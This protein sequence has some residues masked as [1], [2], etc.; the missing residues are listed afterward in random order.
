MKSLQNT[1]RI[2]LISHSL[3]LFSLKYFSL[4]TL[5]QPLEFKGDVYGVHDPT[6]I[7]AEGKYYLFSTGQG[8]QI[9]CSDDLVTWDL[10]SAVYF[11][12]PKWI[13]EE[14]P[15]VS[16][17][18]APDISFYNGRYQVYYSVS[19]F[20]DN[21]SA[22][23]LATNTTLDKHDPEYKWQDQGIV[24]K[25]EQGF[26]WN[27]IDPNFVVDKD[28]QPWLTFGSFWSG[29]KLIKLDKETGKRIEGDTLISI[30]SRSTGPRAI[31]APYIIYR[32]PYYYLFVSF[33]Q[34]CKGVNSTYNTRVGRAEEITGPY[35]DKAGMDMR[36]DGGTLLR[37]GSTRWK[38]AGHS[39]IFTK[40]GIDYLV[41]H[42]YDADNQ[43]RPTLRLEPIQWV[44]GWPTL[45]EAE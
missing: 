29:I 39:A 10:C 35:L 9:R 25:S 24:I 42:S 6:M 19:S 26:D 41:Y 17:L 38:G 30:A 32:E 21:Q 2:F 14:V 15:A 45:G 13:R 22:I 7:E 33:D 40:D 44:D 31:E 12:F 34:C 16:D 11:K 8:L 23:G 28:G 1:G 37:E 43:G 3:F 4:F 5:A 36:Y 20:G 27:A 18:W